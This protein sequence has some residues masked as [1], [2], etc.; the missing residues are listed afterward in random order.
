MLNAHELPAE[1]IAGRHYLIATDGVA[2]TNPGL[3]GWAIA[4]QLRCSQSI[5]RANADAGHSSA[6]LGELVTSTNRMELFAAIKAAESIQEPE[7]PAIIFTKCSIVYGGM[8]SWL[9]RWKEN[10]WKGS[11]GSVK[12][13]DLWE[14]LDAACSGKSIHWIKVAG[15]F[16]HELRKRASSLAT[17]AVTGRY[18]RGMQSVRRQHPSWFC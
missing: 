2:K 11:N 15:S 4:K 7:T 10:G 17:N 8:C 16:R 18:P 6:G 3:G 1:I 12:N 14:Q 9:S 5:L 13:K